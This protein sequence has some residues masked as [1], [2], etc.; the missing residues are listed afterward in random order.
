[1]REA[2]LESVA[3]ISPFEVWTKGMGTILKDNGLEVIDKCADSNYSFSSLVIPPVNL[4]ILA[5]RY[6]SRTPSHV[7][8]RP[9][10]GLYH[11]KIVLVLEP[12]DEFAAE[13][14]VAVDVE[15]LIVSCASVQDFTDCIGS[16]SRAAAGS[17]PL[18]AY[19]SGTASIWRRTGRI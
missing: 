13:D 3:I 18:F 15:G 14:F 16:V 7:L 1:M 12:D 5:W 19:C 9:L 2:H 17:I 6:V 8:F 10:T 4:L 11:G